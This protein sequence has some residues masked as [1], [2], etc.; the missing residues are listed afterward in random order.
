MIHFES[1]LVKKCLWRI[2]HHTCLSHFLPLLLFCCLLFEHP[3]FGAF[4]FG[5]MSCDSFDQ[6]I[7]NDESK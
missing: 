3:D 1:K 5:H 2:E 4:F 6:M 7:K